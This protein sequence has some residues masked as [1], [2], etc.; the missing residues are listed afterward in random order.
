MDFTQLTQSN[1]SK[2]LEAVGAA[3]V[4]DLFRDIPPAARLN[5]PLALPEALTESQL[6]AEMNRLANANRT[7]EE[8]AC[9]LGGGIYDHF[10][11]TVVDELAGQSEFVTA[12]TP[13]QSEVAQGSLQ[14]FYEYQSLICQLTGMDVSNAS[15]YEGATAAAE[16]VLMARA[17]NGRRRVIV[18]GAVHPD[19]RNV[20]ATY[21]RELPIDLVILDTTDGLT[22][23]QDL[24]GLVDADTAAV[25]IQTP[26]F[27]G[28]IEPADELIEIA[29]QAGA[30][31]I[32][33]VDPISCGLLKRPGDIGA[34]I[35][36]GEGQALGIPMFY[37]GPSLGF[38]ACRGEY[39]RR[40][41]GRLI[42][43]TTDRTGR[44]GFCLTLQTREQHIRRERATSNIC[45][46]QG[47]MALRVAVYLSA[48]GRNGLARIAAQCLDK[49]HYAADLLAGLDGFE[50][51]FKGP[52]FK[53][54]VVRTTRSVEQVLQHCRS[55][56]IL[57][58]IP[59][60]IWNEKLSDSFLV[61]VTEKRTRQEIDAWAAALRDAMISG[62]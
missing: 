1:M 26:N 48:I 10:I 9:F 32:V 24:L 29:R 14:V 53:E 37:G 23:P 13:Y 12:Y 11:P 59:L 22:D 33:S 41:P 5:H 38:L 46:N 27:L 52:F 36:V 19:T 47:L 49:A 15:L 28:G 17:I 30:I 51:R 20:L 18:S 55:K 31:A 2:M 7:A 40:I 6:L 54:F 42:G 16:A 8:Q 61:A 57:A 56:G 62:K 39:L 3:G 35:V 60:G 21:L 25:L 58:G 45:T 44:R 4:E 34:D 43:R 50:L